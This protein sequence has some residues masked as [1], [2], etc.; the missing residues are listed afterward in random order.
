MCACGRMELSWGWLCTI[1]YL[2]KE[3]GYVLSEL[4]RH[5]DAWEGKSWHE[6]GLERLRG[7]LNV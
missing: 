7:L 6:Y 5:G 1:C 4:E 3:I 2:Q